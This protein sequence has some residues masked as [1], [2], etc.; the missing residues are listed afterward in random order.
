MEPLNRKKTTTSDQTID[1][2]IGKFYKNKGIYQGVWEPTDDKS[3]IFNLYAAPEDL[4]SINGKNLLLTFNKAAYYLSRLRNW[5]GHG[6]SDLKSAEDIKQAVLNNPE[7]L[8]DWFIPPL[9]LLSGQNTEGKKIQN[10]NL[11]D[12]KE[13]MPENSK[14]VTIQNLNR[15]HLYWSCTKHKEHM[16]GMYAF[17]FADGIPVEGKKHISKFSTRPVRAELRP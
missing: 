9:K 1:L 17:N 10:T 8:S 3:K 4:K 15:T 5:H 13:E 14:F 6:G 2:E 12:K 16:L 7:K 11:Y